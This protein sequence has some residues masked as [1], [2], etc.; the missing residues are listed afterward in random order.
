MKSIAS[1]MIS[2]LKQIEEIKRNAGIERKSI[3]VFAANAW[4]Y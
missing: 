1:I 3:K 4:K 2:V